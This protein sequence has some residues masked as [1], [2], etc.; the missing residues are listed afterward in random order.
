MNTEYDKRR[1]SETTN[2]SVQRERER[3]CVLRG[4]HRLLVTT[5]IYT[6]TNRNTSLT[7]YKLKVVQYACVVY[8]HRA[9]Y[10]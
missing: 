3:G 6:N 8:M 5:D 10:Q 2:R 9:M 7:N 4:S 1:R